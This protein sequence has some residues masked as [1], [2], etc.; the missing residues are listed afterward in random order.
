MLCAGYIVPHS[1]LLLPMIHEEVHDQLLNTIDAYQKTAQ[2][3]SDYNP[4]TIVIISTKAPSYKDYIHI[5]P[6]EQA[7]GNF[8]KYGHSEYAIAVE[9]DTVLVNQI[10]SLAKRNHIPAGKR[11]DDAATLDSGTMVPLFFINQYLNSYRIV[12]ISISDVDKEQLDRLG[13]CI[14]AAAE[15]IDRRIVIIVSGELS[16]RLSKE[17]PYGFDKA[18]AVFDQFILSS[19]KD[20]D[21]EAWN[22]VNSDISKASAQT[23]LPALQIFKGAISDTLYRSTVISY[24]APFGIG[25]TV[26]AFHNKDQNPYCALARSAMLYYLENGKNMT[27]LPIA[28]AALKRRGGV[29]VSLYLYDEL[30]SYAGTIHPLYPTIA[31]EIVYNAGI[32]GFR[33][34]KREPL[35]K[36]QLMRCEIK[37]HVLS[38]YEPVFFIEDLNVKHDGLIVASNQKQGIVFPNTAKIQTPSQLLEQ[39]LKKG[40]ISINEYYTMERFTLEQY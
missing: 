16:K 36:A 40:G 37:I 23:I 19:I 35:S 26:A 33:H 9:Y 8:T 28:D 3:I 34:S 1:P 4:E 22:N 31:Q 18:A 20:N 11:G 15:D 13:Q 32:A 24:E 6:G 21:L 17:S 38:E 30:Y 27:K 39:A 29:I 2:E 12:R 7:S 10:C 5:A 14:A 25:W